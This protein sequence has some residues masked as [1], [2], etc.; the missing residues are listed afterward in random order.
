M[1]MTKP[2]M[3]LRIATVCFLPIVLSAAAI[4]ENGPGE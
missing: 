3:L 2:T 1:T 4:W